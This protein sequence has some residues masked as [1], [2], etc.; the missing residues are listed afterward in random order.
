MNKLYN[1][2]RAKYNQVLLLPNTSPLM[3][4]FILQEKQYRASSRIFYI[5]LEKRLYDLPIVGNPLRQTNN[6]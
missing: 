1:E 5:R 3:L 4:L 6:S 2:E